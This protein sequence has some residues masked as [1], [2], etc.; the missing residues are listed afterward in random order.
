MLPEGCEVWYF[1][2]DGRIKPA[3]ILAVHHDDEVAYYTVR[4]DG[5]SERGKERATERSRIVAM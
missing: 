2:S 3:T 1:H 4:F 5:G